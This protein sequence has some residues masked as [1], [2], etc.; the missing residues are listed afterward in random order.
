MQMQKTLQNRPGLLVH[1]DAIIVIWFSYQ[2]KYRFQSLSNLLDPS[3]TLM[4][5]ESF[6]LPTEFIQIVNSDILG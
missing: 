2:G 6:T 1:V 3:N 4:S 5:I